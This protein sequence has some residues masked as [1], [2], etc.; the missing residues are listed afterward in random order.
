[1]LGGDAT[2]AYDEPGDGL[3]RGSITTRSGVESKVNR[4]KTV[5][6]L[7]LPEWSAVRR[8]LVGSSFEGAII[9][10]FEGLVE[11]PCFLS[12]PITLCAGILSF[13]MMANLPP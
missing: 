2:T 6:G 5:E 3:P 13:C 4:P 9:G 1:V 8:L 11:G 10:L 7:E 12:I